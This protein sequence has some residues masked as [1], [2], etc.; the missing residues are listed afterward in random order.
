MQSLA[1][2][3]TDYAVVDK[4]GHYTVDWQQDSTAAVQYVYQH[5]GAKLLIRRYSRKEWD[6]RGNVETIE[7]QYALEDIGMHPKLGGKIGIRLIDLLDGL[8]GATLDTGMPHYG[9]AHAKRMAYLAMYLAEIENLSPRDVFLLILGSYI[10][11]FHRQNVN[12]PATINMAH[13]SSFVDAGTIINPGRL[14]QVLAKLI[15]C[16]WS[17]TRWQEKDTVLLLQ[18]VS[19]TE[20]MGWASLLHQRLQDV[21]TL[22]EIRFGVTADLRRLHTQTALQLLYISKQELDL[23][24]DRKKF[25]LHAC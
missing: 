4:C 2:T 16:V 1:Q 20:T 22:D 10:L 19:G 15:A 17:R 3:N 12:D 13:F 6:D 21:Q 18:V 25:A 9:R 5:V 14:Q 7:P 11:D 24:P 8:F 23:I